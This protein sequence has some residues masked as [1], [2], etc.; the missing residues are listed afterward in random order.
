[1]VPSEPGPA[2]QDLLPEDFFSVTGICHS[3]H[4]SFPEELTGL[5]L[6]TVVRLDVG[7][8]SVKG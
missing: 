6:S 1:M 5:W 2:F 8:G 4:G 3:F 7:R